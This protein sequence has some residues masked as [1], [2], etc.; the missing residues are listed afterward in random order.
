ME[1]EEG[2]VSS[3]STGIAEI[4]LPSAYKIQNYMETAEATSN[5]GIGN[6]LFS[7]VSTFQRFQKTDPFYQSKVVPSEAVSSLK[8]EDSHRHNNYD[9]NRKRK[10]QKSTDDLALEK[11]KKVI[12]FLFV[13]RYLVFIFLFLACL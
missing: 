1:E 5:H 2:V 13:I 4:E 10:F 6:G 8:G 3:W 7:T 11:Y 12:S 9:N